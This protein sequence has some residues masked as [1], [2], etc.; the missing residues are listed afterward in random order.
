MTRQ[1]TRFATFLRG[2]I[3]RRRK[4]SAMILFLLTI[5]A[6][7][8]V[9]GGVV[10]G[11]IRDLLVNVGASVVI[12][13]LSYAIFDPVF[14]EIRRSPVQEQPTFDD[15]KFSRNV[16]NAKREVTIMDTC[17]HMLE[18][19]D[20]RDIFLEALKRAV[21]RHVI[22]RILLLDPDSSA[23]KQR[24]EEISPVNVRHVTMENLRYLE[25]CRRQLPPSQQDRIQ[26]RIYDALP[27][28][29][30]FQHDFT[31]LVSFFPVGKRASK[32]SHLEIDIDTPLGHFVKSRFDE[33]WDLPSS[34]TMQSWMQIRLEAW[35][36]GHPLGVYEVQ[37][38]ELHER[39]YVNA[40][41]IKG[42]LI[43][44]GSPHVEF[45]SDEL[46]AADVNTLLLT[47]RVHDS[48]LPTLTELS[49]EF[50]MK[51]GA[52]HS[53]DERVILELVPRPNKPNDGW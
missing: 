38:I 5:S 31:A 2:R 28:I 8:L 6:G 19:G 32:S 25:S 23:V 9:V 40:D 26:V 16:A 17:N 24:S 45:T 10:S 1:L 37:Y 13:A 48:S 21:R 11:Y 12:V 52:L 43:S 42:L 3:T 18:G 36:G 20:S 44:H 29:Q 47:S 33:V 30:L 7:M 15:E 14:Q 4:Q 53:V 35:S 22:V 41:S 50:D 49:T 51:Y 39:R 34:R 27:A 46:N